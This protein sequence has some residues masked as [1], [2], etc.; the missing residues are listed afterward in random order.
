MSRRRPRRT[1]SL[2]WQRCILFGVLG[3]LRR[4]KEDVAVLLGVCSRRIIGLINAGEYA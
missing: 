2:Y 3:Y 1:S 4:A